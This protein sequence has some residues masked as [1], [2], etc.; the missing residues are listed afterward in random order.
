MAGFGPLNAGGLV[1]P[2]IDFLDIEQVESGIY[3]VQNV[4]LARLEFR[5]EDV[6]G[7]GFRATGQFS[8]NGGE[9]PSKVILIWPNYFK[10]MFGNK[11]LNHFDEYL[12][13]GTLTIQVK[14]DGN[15]G[16][17]IF[18][19]CYV[20]NAEAP[21]YAQTALP[22]MIVPPAANVG[23]AAVA[24]IAPV[25]VALPLAPVFVFPVA[26]AAQ[27]ASGP[28]LPVQVAL[29]SVNVA[30][31]NGGA[32]F[33]DAAQAAL[34]SVATSPLTSDAQALSRAHANGAVTV[35]TDNLEETSDEEPVIQVEKPKKKKLRN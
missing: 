21:I 22:P 3:I 19:R 34:P 5:G 31:T 13:I 26:N 10:K 33:E 20:I 35:N 18:G 2:T 24:I 14:K 15:Y 30:P 27:S 23:Q 7:G 32:D 28:I 1:T 25:Q 6:P 11:S 12:V 4:A 16:I 17:Q 8:G 9:L 29:P